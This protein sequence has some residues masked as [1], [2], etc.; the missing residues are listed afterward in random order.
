MHP[1]SNPA[2]GRV[3]N[4]RKRPETSTSSGISR[5][6]TFT[7]RRMFTS[8]LSGWNATILMMLCAPPLLL[9]AAMNVPTLIFESPDQQAYFYFA[10]SLNQ[11]LAS[12]YALWLAALCLVF[13]VLIPAPRESYSKREN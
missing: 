1:S 6:A 13:A 2:I 12:S 4:D 9:F 8:T 10:R 11:E 7:A 5:L 3:S